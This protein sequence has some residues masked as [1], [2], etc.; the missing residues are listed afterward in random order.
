MTRIHNRFKKISF[1]QY[2]AFGTLFLLL[3][4]I[5]ITITSNL[6]QHGLRSSAASLPV[7]S[8]LPAETDCAA[9]VVKTPEVIPE[10]QTAN[11]TNVFASG[12]RLTGS[13]LGTYDAAYQS[14]VT[15][16]FSGTTD[17]I[18]QWGACKWG[19]NADTVRA[20][21]ATI[22][23]WKQTALAE[24]NNQGQIQPETNGC[25]SVGIMR[26]KSANIPPTHAGTWPYAKTS[27]AFNI[28][29]ALGV[30]R[31]CYEGK[32][33]SL[34]GGTN[35]YTSGDLMGCIG[36]WYSG[37]WHDG[38]S[39]G[40]SLTVQSTEQNKEWLTLGS[41][42]APSGAPGAMT[43]PNNPI[44][45]TPS[46]FPLAPC[47]TC[48]TVPSTAPIISGV[49]STPGT[50]QSPTVAVSTP[51]PTIDPCV[52]QNT[53]IA[54]DNRHR[55]KGQKGAISNGTEQILK[56]LLAFLELLIQLLGG[57]QGS[58]PNPIPTPSSEP[59]PSDGP[60]PSTAPCSPSTLPTAVPT[61]PVEPTSSS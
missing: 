1:S 3:G 15:G 36:A 13:P 46:F 51:A 42:A 7:G 48:S 8:A 53:S 21:A 54:N 19:I 12:Y 58:S 2:L 40:F 49:V 47:P 45:T 50:S 31:A 59:L 32:Q 26:I 55:H 37:A 11:N 57:G 41:G 16:N 14:R 18:L 56:F 61:L 4:A 23:K 39:E 35:A 60:V 43:V 30:I 5:F 10:N 24:C 27:T 34:A 33:S 22:S 38:A 52:A 25:Q 44:G 6:Q 28:D 17:E 20:I 9:R 29:Y